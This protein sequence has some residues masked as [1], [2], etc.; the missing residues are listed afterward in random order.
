MLYIEKGNQ[1]DKLAV[2]HRKYCQLSIPTTVQFI[3]L[4]VYASVLIS[5]RLFRAKLIL[6][7]ELGTKFQM[8]AS[9]LL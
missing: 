9:L 5:V 3:T 4:Y 8:E 1:C 2:D 7:P 6:S